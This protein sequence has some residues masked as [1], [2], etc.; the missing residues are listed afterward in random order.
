MIAKLGLVLI[1]GLSSGSARCAEG[2]TPDDY[3]TIRNGSSQTVRT[4]V[5]QGEYSGRRTV[6]IVMPSGARNAG[7]GVGQCID[8]PMIAL[9]EEGEEIDRVEPP[10]CK[11]ETWI[12][13]DHQD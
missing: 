3:I 13:R 2:S 10:L 11:G 7:P 8:G 5:V 9:D 12:I 6:P 1:L 4:L